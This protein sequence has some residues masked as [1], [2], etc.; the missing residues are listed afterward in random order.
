MNVDLGIWEKL[1]R[2]VVF[3]L[4]VAGVL[5]IVV[6]YLPLIRQNERVRQE[7]MR[8]TVQVRLEEERGRQLET[9][10]RALK[11]DPRALER[12]AREKLGYV[13]P[14]ETRIQFETS[15][16]RTGRR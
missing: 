5:G 11:T 10:I 8:K 15:A 16:S 3:L 14:G 12:L 1:R 7:I 9:A 6:W 2:L 4:F 13:K